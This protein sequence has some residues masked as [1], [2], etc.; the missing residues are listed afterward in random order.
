MGVERD[1]RQANENAFTAWVVAV[2][3]YLGQDHFWVYAPYS[4]QPVGY[5]GQEELPGRAWRNKPERDGGPAAPIDP[6]KVELANYL[7]LED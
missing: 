1:V 3:A 6:F 5:D 7:V 2:C 4:V